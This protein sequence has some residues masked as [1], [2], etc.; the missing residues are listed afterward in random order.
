MISSKDIAIPNNNESS[1]YAGQTVFP[2]AINEALED[3]ARAHDLVLRIKNGLEDVPAYASSP[4]N[5]YCNIHLHVNNAIESSVRS[6]GYGG[7]LVNRLR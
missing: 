4:I 1:V 2:E 5:N 3:C 6:I 7:S